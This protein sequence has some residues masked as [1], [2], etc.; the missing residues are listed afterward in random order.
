M[1]YKSF[2]CINVLSNMIWEGFVYPTVFGGQ[3]PPK[4]NTILKMKWNINLSRV[5]CEVSSIS[6]YTSFFCQNVYCVSVLIIAD[7]DKLQHNQPLL[8][9]P[10]CE[11]LNTLDPTR[12]TFLVALLTSRHHCDTRKLNNV[13]CA[14]QSTPTCDCLQKPALLYYISNN[15]L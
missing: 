12:G 11:R 7:L 8:Q 6:E 10:D 14:S 13:I 2:K 4:F 15:I 5:L 9:H 3:I 1:N